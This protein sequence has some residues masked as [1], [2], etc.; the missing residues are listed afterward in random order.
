MVDKITPEQRSSVMSKVKGKDTKIERYVRSALHRQ[1]FRFRKNVSDLPGKP[2]I[3]LPKYKCVIFING[4]FWHQHEGCKRATIP[5][6]RTEYWLNKLAGNVERDKLNKIK[7]EM[8][9]W[10]VLT[11][12]ECSFRSVSDEKRKPV[13]EDLINSI[14]KEK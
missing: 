2:D 14:L 12:W 4:C 10:K 1:G 3:V 11:L 7:L 5:Q 9:G 6:T 13:I 8:Q